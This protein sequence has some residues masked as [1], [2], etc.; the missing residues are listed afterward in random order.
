MWFCLGRIARHRHIH[1]PEILDEGDD[2]E[3]EEEEDYLAHRSRDLGSRVRDR[4]REE[5]SE[6]EVAEEKEDEGYSR[7]FR[8]VDRRDQAP[9]KTYRMEVEE[10]SSDEEELDEEEI[11]RRRAAMRARARQRVQ[12]DIEVQANLLIQY[13]FVYM[14]SKIME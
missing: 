11:E 9:S 13:P 2:E 5:S 3:D 7:S 14:G 8:E 6:E 4:Q 10:S 1:G 12:E